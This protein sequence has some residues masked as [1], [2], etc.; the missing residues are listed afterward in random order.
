MKKLRKVILMILI[1]IG[2]ILVNTNV[3]A[4]TGTTTESTTRLREAATTESSTVTLIS[5]NQK[6]DILSEEGEWYK[7][8]YV[9]NGKTLTGY[10]RKDMLSVEGEA[11]T[12]DTNTEA[13]E[14]SQ[15]ETNNEQQNQEEVKKENNESNTLQEG[16]T[17]SISSKVEIKIVPLINSTSLGEIEANSTIEVSEIIN[18]WCYIKSDFISGWTLI[19]KVQSN[20]NV[21]TEIPVEEVKEPVEEIKSEE[22]TKKEE[23]VVDEKKDDKISL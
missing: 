2:L 5:I 14:N 7:V 15:E 8:K 4:A 10:I 12:L 18:K 1:Y 13:Q 11:T 19:S 22:E 9:T 23:P 20:N 21:E 17:G 3:F 6:V 16:Y